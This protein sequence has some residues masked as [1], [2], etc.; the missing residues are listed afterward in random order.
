MLIKTGLQLMNYKILKLRMHVT[1]K[2]IYFLE[3]IIYSNLVH[4]L[5]TIIQ[6]FNF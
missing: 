3:H 2:N 4:C 6:I 5:E 1:G